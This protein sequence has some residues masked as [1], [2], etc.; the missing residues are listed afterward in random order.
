MALSVP[1][2]NVL[3]REFRCLLHLNSQECM[4]CQTLMFIRYKYEVAYQFI[5]AIGLISSVD[6]FIIRADGE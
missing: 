4:S 6:I 2:V 1:V 5:N 3:V